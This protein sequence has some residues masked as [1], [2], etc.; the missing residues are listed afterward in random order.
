MSYEIAR[1]VD[2]LGHEGK[3]T[4][5]RNFQKWAKQ[6]QYANQCHAVLPV[7]DVLGLETRDGTNVNPPG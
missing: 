4:V 3:R 7:N 6:L 2:S 1:I 5:A